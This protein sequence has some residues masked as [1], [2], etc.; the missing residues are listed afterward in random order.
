MKTR[1][2]QFL[3]VIERLGVTQNARYGLASTTRCRSSHGDVTS[4][5]VEVVLNR[6]RHWRMN[7]KPVSGG[8]KPRHRTNAPV[9]TPS[10][11]DI[12][13]Q[14]VV[15]FMRGLHCLE[16]RNCMEA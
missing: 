5:G 6:V 3:G 14:D 1:I 10:H 4:V 8:G 13:R 11:L 7:E 9:W 15:K 16:F 12:I 2:T